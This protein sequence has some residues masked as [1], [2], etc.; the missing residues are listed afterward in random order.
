MPRTTEELFLYH[1]QKARYYKNLLVIWGKDVKKT[2]IHEREKQELADFMKRYDIETVL[3]SQEQAF[4]EIK[5]KYIHMM[6]NKGY[7]LKRIWDIL[8]MCHSGI[9]YLHNTYNA[10][11]TRK[12]AKKRMWAKKKIWITKN[13]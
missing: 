9:L 13:I 8:N 2:N 10:D 3:K 1:S 4:I 11:G 7:T 12:Q 6:R 5:A